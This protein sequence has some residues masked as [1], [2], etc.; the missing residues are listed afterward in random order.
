MS[1]GVASQLAKEGPATEVAA[2]GSL[3]LQLR[4]RDNPGSLSQI[5]HG[6]ES[7]LAAFE[8]VVATRE[9]EIVLMWPR[10]LN[11]VALL[12]ALA[13]LKRLGDCDRT[14]LT[15]IQFPWNRNTS[16]SQRQI[17]ADREYIH[18]TVLPPLNRVA[19]LDRNAPQNPAYSYILGLH[20]LK[21]VKDGEKEARLRARIEH[22]PEREHPTLFELM[23]EYG[24]DAT[25]LHDYGEHFLGFLRKYSS[26]PERHFKPAVD[27]RVTPFLQI[28]F[29]VDAPIEK[30]LTLAGLA[31]SDSRRRPDIILADLTLRVRQRLDHDWEPAFK[32]VLNT[33][34]ELY[35]EDCPPVLAITDDVFTCQKLRPIVREHDR[36]FAPNL[37]TFARAIRTQVV[38]SASSNPLDH[39][40]LAPSP[41]LT[42]SIEAYGTDILKFV[43]LGFDLKRELKESGAREIAETVGQAVGALQNLL[44]IPGQPQAFHNF[45]TEKYDG[46]ERQ[47]IGARFDYGTPRSHLGATL[48][49]GT[50]GP[51]H[52]KLGAFL[53]EFDRL[54]A[55]ANSDNLGRRRFDD[56]VRYIGHSKQN[57]WLVLP[58]ELHLAF[59]EWRIQNDPAFVPDKVQLNERLAL[60][61]ITQ[62]ENKIAEDNS[63]SV[64]RVVFVEPR[65]DDLLAS[66]TLSGLPQ[67][68]M[69]SANLARIEQILRRARTLASLNGIDQ[70]GEPL[71]ALAAEC[72]RVLS[73]HRADIGDLD[74]DFH[75]SQVGTL[76]LTS[77]TYGG[78]GSGLVRTIR[79]SGPLRVRAFDGSEFAVYEPDALRHF[80][81]KYAKD[82]IPGDQVCVFDAEYTEALRARL[83]QSVHAPEV[84]NV[85]HQKVADAADAIPG[86]RDWDMKAQALR[87]RILQID[88][89]LDLPSLDS[90]RRW[91]DVR[92]LIDAPRDAVRPHA[93]RERRQFMAFM[94]ALKISDVASKYYWDW[95]V[96]LTRSDRIKGGASFHHSF[97]GILI[98]PDS[99]ASRWPEGL[100]PEIWK[101]YDSADDY[102]ATVISNF[103]GEQ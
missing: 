75:S 33:A 78:T 74:E 5:S 56:L 28:G 12:H 11:G 1:N 51:Q 20:S 47:R 42:F 30:A 83:K 25:G 95:G 3:G 89:T 39:R 64:E 41:A 80:A 43:E 85:Y 52:G 94:K 62:L 14:P 61:D 93:P 96:S 76:D 98:D 101:I 36:S 71:T 9:S 82:L 67:N 73:G 102:I 7:A 99:T 63:G 77:G 40:A 34:F 13:G 29:G 35:L 100:R 26:L 90:I 91:I 57:T 72:D 31:P 15:T 59:A 69:I 86:E 81:R 37:N 19:P 92:S 23:P 97:M 22:K 103:A 24:I 4:S 6:V 65:P 49:A 2:S 48:R 21:H 18:R 54:I 16:R 45:F 8:R 38:L 60:I 88:P 79:L 50:A 53:K 70:F 27:P 17:L 44:S 10:C 87:T 55:I 32:A 66:L 84:L 46:H 68:I 58:Y